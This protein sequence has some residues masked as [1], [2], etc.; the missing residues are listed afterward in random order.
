MVY[1]QNFRKGN[2]NSTKKFES[3]NRFG[4]GGFK[5]PGSGSGS[6]STFGSGSGESK[7]KASRSALHSTL[8]VITH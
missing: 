1:Q 3:G 2:Y 5:K 8:H 4:G 7:D 6:N